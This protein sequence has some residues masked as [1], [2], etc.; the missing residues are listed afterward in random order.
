ME[1]KSFTFENGLEFSEE[2]E[3]LWMT[4]N[5]SG[6][7]LSFQPFYFETPHSFAILYLLCNYNGL[8]FW[9]FS[10]KLKTVHIT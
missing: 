2:N 6:S 10:G 4:L 7:T 1:G 8:Q 5:V 9:A 3:R